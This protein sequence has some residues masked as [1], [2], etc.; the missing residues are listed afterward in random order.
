MRLPRRVLVFLGLSWALVAL[1][2]DPTVLVASVRNLLAPQIEPDAARSLAATLP[3]DPREVERR[4]L[5]DVVPYGS[6]WE[7]A[8]VPWSFPT[9]AQA[10]RAGRGDCES[11][12]L[13]LASVLSAKGI[14][15]ELRMSLDH[16]WVDYAGKVPTAAENDARVLA[17]RGSGGWFGLRWPG[18]LDLRRELRSQAAIYWDPMPAGRKVLLFAGLVWIVL[19]NML[20]PMLT[21][22]GTAQVRRHTLGSVKAPTP[23]NAGGPS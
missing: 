20:A 2:P 19:W 16:I 17:G 8:G 11:R 15:N 1:Y 14:P 21:H 9:A 22:P 18:D 3:D 5:D 6:D 4:V 23:S 10:L 7:T 13:V 12:A